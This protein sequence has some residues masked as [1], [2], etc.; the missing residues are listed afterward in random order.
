MPSNRGH[1]SPQTHKLPDTSSKRTNVTTLTPLFP[2]KFYSLQ[3]I[4]DE[5]EQDG[6]F[7][8]DNT[9]DAQVTPKIP[10][11]NVYNISNYETFYS[12]L[13]NQTFDDFS[14]TDTKT[15]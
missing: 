13:F 5:M 14:I 15:H 8:N 3:N 2:N 1:R 11:I 4:D 6:V 12:S 7:I 9:H 10:P